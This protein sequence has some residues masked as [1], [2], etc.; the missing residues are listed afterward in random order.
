MRALIFLIIATA[1]FLT[2][3]QQAASAEDDFGQQLQNLA[4]RVN[5]L[6]SKESELLTIA[7]RETGGGALFL[8]GA[9]CALWAQNTERSAWLWFFMGL[10]FSVITVIVLLSKNSHD[11]QAATR[12]S[13]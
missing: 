1:L 5:Q 4:Q 8:F 11:R 3:C 6:E 13:G 2:F 10:L 12:S 9:F 7:H